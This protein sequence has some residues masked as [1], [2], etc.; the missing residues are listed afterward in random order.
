M[1]RFFSLILLVILIAT[2][3]IALFSCSKGER[4]PDGTYVGGIAHDFGEEYTF[5]GRRVRVV[6]YMFGG[7]VV[8]YSGTYTL[9][10]DEI[11]FRFPEDEDGLY[12]RTLKFAL[13]EDGKSITIDGDVFWLVSSDDVTTGDQ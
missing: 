9:S 3:S 2:A 12:S 13:S 11:I 10:G 6:S 7:I 1:K 8:D 4:V 5:T